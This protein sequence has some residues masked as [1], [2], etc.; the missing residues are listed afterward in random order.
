MALVLLTRTDGL[1]IAVDSTE[2]FTLE[3][4]PEGLVEPAFF[5]ATFIND[6]KSV[7]VVGTVAEVAAKLAPVPPPPEPTFGPSPDTIVVGNVPAGDPSQL[8]PG[9]FGYIPDIGDGNGIRDALDAVA[10][11]GGG[12][13]HIR[14]GLYDF[15][16]L[17]SPALPLLING[18]RV[19]GDGCSTILRMS[20]TDRRLFVMETGGPNGING[21][22]PELAHMGIDYTVAEPGA[23]GD[24]LIDAF[25]GAVTSR[26]ATIENVEV[27]KN[28]GGGAAA[29][30]INDNESLTSIF[31]T[32]IAGRVF[33]CKCINVDGTSGLTVVAFRLSGNL[34]RVAQCAV[35]GAN[36]GF[37][38]ESTRAL[39]EGGSTGGGPITSSHIGIVAAA[40]G[41]RILA[42]DV[43]GQDGIVLLTGGGS[44]V[45]GNNIAFVFGDGIR[46]DA[47]A[48]GSVV[49]N[50]RL[51]GSQVVNNGGAIVANNPP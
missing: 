43:I 11:G 31:R 50:N 46:V 18:T 3:P 22:A 9:A 37:G 6:G 51:N 27:I 25:G 13:V 2:V 10:A 28:L 4:V 49:T 32:G 30:T 42:N 12:Q 17:S 29:P 7:S 48:T 21:A 38:I 45:V 1:E 5:P 23:V 20:T 47:G 33:D 35:N 34:S 24:V 44:I 26:R 16:L 40:A 39:V 36:V 15:G 14:S 19:T 41:A 8:Q